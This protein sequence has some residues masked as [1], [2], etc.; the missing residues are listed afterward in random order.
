MATLTEAATALRAHHSI[1]NGRD[2]I[3]AAGA[4]EAVSPASGQPFAETSLLTAAQAGGALDA[5]RA[6]FP[7][8]SARPFGERAR[9]L[10]AAREVLARQAD[11]LRPLDRS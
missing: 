5:A 2:E 3:G 8:W 1:V 9:Y 11:E 10:L 6:A 4:R 7:A